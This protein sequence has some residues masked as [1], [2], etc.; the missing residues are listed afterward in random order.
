M[1][2]AKFSEL[3]DKRSRMRA[4]KKAAKEIKEA[5]IK[6]LFSPELQG[7]VRYAHLRNGTVEREEILDASS[8][9]GLWYFD[10]L[11]QDH[12]LFQKSVRAQMLRLHNPTPQGGMIRY[13]HDEY[14]RR[15]ELSNPWII[16][17]LWEAQR[18]LTAPDVTLDDLKFCE[19]Q[20]EWV[21]QHR[22][23]SG[24]LP[25]QFD[26][27]SGES[28]SATPLVWSHAVYVETLL[29]YVQV[30]DQLQQTTERQAKA[31]VQL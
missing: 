2:A 28:L 16:T 23:L 9:F 19:Q 30:S 15:G 31:I 10:M 14:F 21:Y 17:T 26:P 20:L 3:L 18:R 29:K 6:H 25:E 22:Y 24:I 8:L 11:E 1:A 12:P 13:E 4:F 5:T 27:Q 7:F